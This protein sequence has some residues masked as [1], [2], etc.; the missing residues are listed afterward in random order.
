MTD[1]SQVCFEVIHRYLTHAIFMNLHIYPI[2]T[3]GDISKLKQF[4]G[5]FLLGNYWRIYFLIL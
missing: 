3:P 5:Y 2:E 1:I 4:P